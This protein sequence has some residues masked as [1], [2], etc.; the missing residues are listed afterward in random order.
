MKWI[1]P[2]QR[3]AAVFG[4]AF[5]TLLVVTGCQTSSHPVDNEKLH[6]LLRAQAGD[7]RV[8]GSSF[9][10]REGDIVQITFPGAANLNTTQLV[11]RD[12]KIEMPLLGEL[13]AA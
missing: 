10:I 8:M 3:F 4:L 13:Q 7:T 9:T 11:R 5:F 2:I 1:N 12:G 6:E